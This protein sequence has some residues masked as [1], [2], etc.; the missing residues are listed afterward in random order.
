[1]LTYTETRSSLSETF[2]LCDTVSINIYRE[3]AN[4]PGMRNLGTESKGIEIQRRIY[5][6]IPECFG[7]DQGISFPLQVGDILLSS[8]FL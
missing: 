7:E 5:L 8:P 2:H 6:D 3:I 4:I 1:L